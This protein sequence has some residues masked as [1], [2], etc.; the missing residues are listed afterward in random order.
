[1]H[2]KCQ[3]PTSVPFLH[4]GYKDLLDFW[5]NWDQICLPSWFSTLE[6]W[7]FKLNISLP[8]CMQIL[9]VLFFILAL[10]KTTSVIFQSDTE[11]NYQGSENHG[12]LANQ[13]LGNQVLGSFSADLW[14]LSPRPFSLKDLVSTSKSLPLRPL[15]LP[16]SFLLMPL[17]PALHSLHSWSLCTCTRGKEQ[18]ATLVAGGLWTPRERWLQLHHA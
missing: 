12:H 6:G 11:W 5:Q 13:P 3:L 14:R 15:N 18:K 8:T 1:M 2:N 9:S 10:P 7:I 17:S 4:R 16:K